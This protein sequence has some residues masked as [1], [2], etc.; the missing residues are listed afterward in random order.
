MNNR[1]SLPLAVALLVNFSP[2]L[3]AADTG[4][5]ARPEELKYPALKYEVPNQADYRVTLK[6]GPVA[7]LV[8]DK[9][10]PLVNISILVRTG[11]Y[12]VPVGKEG[13]AQITGYLLARGGT[14]S[15]TAE[16]MEERLAFLAA[17]LNS[18]VGENQGS[19]SLELLSKD[20]D[21][22][23]GILK[24]VLTAPRFQD[25]KIALYKDQTLQVM[26]QRNDDSSDI[27]GREKEF[28]AYGENFWANRQTT[29]ASLDSI[30]KVDIEQFHKKWFHPA[31]FIVSVNGDFDREAMTQKLEKLF[32]DWPFQ[33]EKPGP[34]PT[35]TQFAKPGV[36]VVDKEVNQGRV[37]IMLPGIKRD[38]PDFFPIIIMNDVLGGGGFTS[39]IMNR[40]RSDEGLAYSAGSSFPGGIYY[41]LTFTA[42]FQSK[43]RTVAYAVSIVLDEM[44]K[45]GSTTP[46]N[47]EL[48]TSKNGI[49]DRFPRNF[50]TKGQ[51]A[52]TFA[53]DEYT[54][55]YAQNPEFWKNYRKN[56]EAVSTE[57]VQRVAKKYLT[58]DNLA[59]LIVGD[60]KEIL[61]GH[62][63]YKASLK[64]I[65]KDK[66]VDVPL[67]DPLTMKPI[68]K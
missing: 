38:N 54:G 55:R 67:R 51:I 48:S 6:S 29:A 24:E 16:E 39:H 26:K 15:K 56:V 44:K 68:T 52:A 30:S 17:H 64:E 35:D 43:S 36:Y 58:E 22:G 62:P 49:I 65:A 21:E 5:P 33:G 47:E 23:V 12:L 2:V 13:L 10:R 20:V 4:I 19:V 41:P 8:P 53:Q 9:E 18:G 31:N 27:E 37:S 61:A 42:G 45:M 28:L 11:D 34:I 46:D 25:D 59:I 7:Y 40:V 57:D 1:L 63:N 60:K 50:A 66:I 32:S 3:Q 14:K